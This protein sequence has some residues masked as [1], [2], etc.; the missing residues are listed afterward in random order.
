M[1]H[2]KLLL[3]LG[4]AAGLTFLGCAREEEEQ[5]GELTETAEEGI[6]APEPRAIETDLDAVGESGITG[7]AL[8][9]PR[10]D[11]IAV[12]LTLDGAAIDERYVAHIHRGECGNDLGMVTP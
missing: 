3:I 5:V 8:L 7:Q 1:F 6:R 9:T 10:D 4:L 12:E 2:H 11:Q